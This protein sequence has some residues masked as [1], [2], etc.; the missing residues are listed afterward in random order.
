ML[1]MGEAMHVWVQ[2]ACD[3][4]VLP[5]Q[6]CCKSKM[7]LKVVLKIKWYLP[8]LVLCN[9][10]S[11][12][13]LAQWVLAGMSSR[14]LFLIFEG[15]WIYI[16]LQKKIWLQL[17]TII[18]L[19]SVDTKASVRNDLFCHLLKDEEINDDSTYVKDWRCGSWGFSKDGSIDPFCKLGE[20]YQDGWPLRWVLGDKQQLAIWSRGWSQ[21]FRKTKLYVTMPVHKPE[22]SFQES[23][24]VL[25]KLQPRI[26]YGEAA[27][28]TLIRL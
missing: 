16:L 18:V 13:I 2:R 28:N 20:A 26:K 10:I 12:Y 8:N 3:F 27:R 24:H 21:S 6:F 19:F 17:I 1:I 4:F 22:M 9:Y 5:S 7:S 14:I 25:V 11:L 23:A 15:G